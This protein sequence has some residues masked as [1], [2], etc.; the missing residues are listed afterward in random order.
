M[1]RCNWF[2]KW[3]ISVNKRFETSMLRSYLCASSDTYIIVKGKINLTA[4]AMNDNGKAEND[5]SFKYNAP[6]IMYFKN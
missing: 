6:L 5:V 2:I 1:G 4:A 3:T